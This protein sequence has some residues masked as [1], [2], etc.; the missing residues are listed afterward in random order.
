ME[1]RG[2]LLLLTQAQA[3]E[4]AGISEH[5]QA[6]ARGG[7]GKDG[8]GQRHSKNGLKSMQ[9]GHSACLSGLMRMRLSILAALLVMAILLV[10]RDEL[11]ARGAV[12]Q[13]Y[14]LCINQ[15]HNDW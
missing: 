5:Q 13:G 1:R 12:P 7:R 10:F 15:V 9:S 8:S 11:H 2:G 4:N 6:L 3:A 14:P